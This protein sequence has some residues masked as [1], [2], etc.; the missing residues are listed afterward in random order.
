MTLL[1]EQ[2]MAEVVEAMARA[3]CRPVLDP[4]ETIYLGMY[5]K[6][7]ESRRQEALQALTAALPAIERAVLERAATRVEDKADYIARFMAQGW[8]GNPHMSGDDRGF[9]PVSQ[10]RRHDDKCLELAGELA[11]SIRALAGEVG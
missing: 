6:A 9:M 1:T 11:S 8:R 10:R 2:Q 7:W 4:D 5:I 3:M